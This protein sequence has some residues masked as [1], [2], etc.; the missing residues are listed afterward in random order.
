[1]D[2]WHGAGRLS[3]A[4]PTTRD[5]RVGPDPGGL[6]CPRTLVVASGHPDVTSSSLA[7]AFY[8][9]SGAAT[10]SGIL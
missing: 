7:Q 3:P 4:L 10:F 2:K 1:M 6:S 8:S 9:D 5:K